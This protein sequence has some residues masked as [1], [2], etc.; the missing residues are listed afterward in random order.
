M[1]SIIT[2]TIESGLSLQ[3]AASRVLH[4]LTAVEQR[5]LRAEKWV[6]LQ[7]KRQVIDLREEPNIEKAEDI[8]N[9]S[10]VVLLNIA[11]RTTL[12]VVSDSYKKAR[13]NKP[14]HQA[15]GIEIFDPETD[16]QV[17]SM[18]VTFDDEVKAQLHVLDFLVIE[19]ANYLLAKMIPVVMRHSFIPEPQ[20]GSSMKERLT[21]IVRATLDRHPAV[22][23]L[24]Q[25]IEEAEFDSTNIPEAFLKEHFP[26]V[27]LKIFS[28]YRQEIAQ[29]NGR[30]GITFLRMKPGYL[31]HDRKQLQEAF[32][33]LANE[34]TRRSIGDAIDQTI[35]SDLADYRDT[36][37]EELAPVG[38][39]QET[40][41]ANSDLNFPILFGTFDEEGKPINGI[42]L[43]S[44]VEILV[45]ANIT[46][47]T[48]SRLHNETINYIQAFACEIEGVPERFESIW[49]GQI[50]TI[51]DQLTIVAKQLVQAK[52]NVKEPGFESRKR[53]REP[54]TLMEARQRAR[55]EEAGVK[56]ELERL[57]EQRTSINIRLEGI[58]QGTL[59]L[60]DQE[61]LETLAYLEECY[62][63]AV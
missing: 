21:E 9:L 57:G 40:I 18:F 13:E 39:A 15:D 5:S 51:E 60:T 10:T 30:V 3:E 38:Q 26:D 20:F 24:V 48:T 42:G 47:Q 4:I 61:A 36:L 62:T 54:E 37:V 56:K 6:F 49:I 11:A 53:G 41:E 55:G 19:E 32:N 50:E 46:P 1:E 45:E 31:V 43:Q 29:R 52:A 16:G 22:E 44:A 63:E 28:G 12:G 35:L 25:E 14:V 23:G 7:E 33:G 59:T 17:S 2:P 8:T 34:I 58:A 27:A